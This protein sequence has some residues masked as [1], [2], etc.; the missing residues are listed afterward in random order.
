MKNNLYFKKL[1]L[2]FKYALSA[3]VWLII[4]QIAAVML[5]VE[6]FLPTPLSVCETLFT[7]L[8]IS[9]DFWMSILFSLSHIL[10][11]F[12]A[13]FVCG[14]LLAALS[15][16]CKSVEIFLWFPLKIIQ[17]T[18]VASF[19][20]L[21]LLWIPSSGLSI[22]ISFLMVLPTMYTSTLAGLKQTD[23][24]LLEMAQ[25]FNVSRY[26]KI[27]YIYIPQL[28]PYALSAAS[29]AI[30]FAWKSGIAAEIIGL[31]RHSIGNQLYQAKIYFLTPDLFAW[32]LVIIIL[33]IICEQLM[34][35]A[36]NYFASERKAD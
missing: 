22:I 7:K 17:A 3:A 34:K 19:V 26:Q 6:L 9:R 28:L 32:T 27:I 1:P 33:S 11:G 23:Y 10:C 31:V 24:R 5:N 13:G 18:P 30:G 15:Y 29:L 8:I 16:V 4:W 2:F 14:I 36:Y 20:I 35:L 12:I 25:V 21:I